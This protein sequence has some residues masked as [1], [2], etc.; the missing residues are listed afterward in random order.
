MATNDAIRHRAADVVPTKG[1]TAVLPDR[2]ATTDGI[3]RHR[4]IA[5]PQIPIRTS[6]RGTASSSVPAIPTSA[7]TLTRISADFPLLLNGVKE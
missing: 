1:I 3:N 4:V 7:G 6:G 5:L 2:T